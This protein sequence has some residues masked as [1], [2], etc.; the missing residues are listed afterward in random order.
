MALDLAVEVKRHLERRKSLY[1]EVQ[2]PFLTAAKACFITPGEQ[3]RFRYS[4]AILTYDLYVVIG[5]FSREFNQLLEQTTLE[6]FLDKNQAYTELRY[7]QFSSPLSGVFQ[8]IWIPR[9]SEK[10][11]SETIKQ[12]LRRVSEAFMQIANEVDL[13]SEKCNE[14][15]HS[16]NLPIVVP[17]QYRSIQTSIWPNA[18]R[19]QGEVLLLTKAQ[20]LRVK[21]RVYPPAHFLPQFRSYVY[22][23]Y[24]FKVKSDRLSLVAD[25]EYLP[26]AE[27]LLRMLR[28]KFEQQVVKPLA[29][30]ASYVTELA[31]P[32]ARPDPQVPRLGRECKLFKNELSEENYKSFWKAIDQTL[33][34][35]VL[36]PKIIDGW[37]HFEGRKWHS[38]KDGKEHQSLVEWLFELPFHFQSPPFRYIYYVKGLDGFRVIPTAYA[39]QYAQFQVLPG[40]VTDREAL[41]MAT[42]AF[43]MEKY[44]VLEGRESME[45][46]LAELPYS[47]KIEFDRLVEQNLGKCEELGRGGFGNIYKNYY[48]RNT[49]YKEDII[50][51]AL[52]VVKAEKLG[53]RMHRESLI[54]EYRLLKSIDH[55]NILHVYGYTIEPASHNIVLVLEL[56]DNKALGKYLLVNSTL[57]MHK[58]LKLLTGMANGLLFLHSRGIAHLDIKPQNILI[59]DKEVPKISDLGLSKRILPTETLTKTGYTLLYSAPEQIEG[60]KV[61]LFADIWAFGNLIYYVLFNKAPNDRLKDPTENVHSFTTRKKVV[62]ALVAEKKRP[63]VPDSFFNYSLQMMD[64]TSISAPFAQA[65]N[66]PHG[67]EIVYPKL[68][69]LMRQCWQLDPATRP[70]ARKLYRTLNKEY[71]KEL[72]AMSQVRPNRSIATREEAKETVQP[73]VLSSAKPSA[74][75]TLEGEKKPDFPM[76]PGQYHANRPSA[77]SSD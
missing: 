55:D 25:T 27:Q 62:E 71:Q 3:F 76:I 67:F 57:E 74:Q 24:Q 6:T 63:L 64:V 52:K 23:G 19:L 7:L 44:S 53:K 18:A 58:R 11:L 13:S 60:K 69:D 42:M 30:D 28:E 61:G 48:K 50:K 65:I 14:W 36:V 77:H 16:C 20:R 59:T 47:D 45:G 29:S 34:P 46:L 40:P 56:C 75:V 4:C 33:R 1:R 21:V 39:E 5:A 22:V 70:T 51:V 49:S 31:N 38:M 66:L 2:P 17:G 43:V 41:Y 72:K 10:L 68:V 32:P 9:G 15:F 37:Y 54:Q 12:L 35:Y 8:T 26:E 73:G